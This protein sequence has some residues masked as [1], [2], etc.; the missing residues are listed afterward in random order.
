MS[1]V[2][3][4]SKYAWFRFQ[5]EAEPEFTALLYYYYVQS[6]SCDVESWTENVNVRSKCECSHANWQNYSISFLLSVC[7][8]FWF[9]LACNLG[10]DCKRW[11]I[12][13]P[14]ILMY[15]QAFTSCFQIISF[16]KCMKEKRSLENRERS[17]FNFVQSSRRT[18]SSNGVVGN[19]W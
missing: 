4:D 16:K 10:R 12:S 8:S 19:S 18:V 6:E 13:F 2:W 7:V 14:R 15:T 3:Q 9:C 11:S 17:D 5:N 1:F